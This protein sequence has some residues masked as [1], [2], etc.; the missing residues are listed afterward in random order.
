MN[1]FAVLNFVVIKIEL[2]CLN[3]NMPDTHQRILFLPKYM[4]EEALQ[5][6]NILLLTTN[7]IILRVHQAE[8]H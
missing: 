5:T 7:E 4:L 3:M 8:L 6:K 1:I 2:T